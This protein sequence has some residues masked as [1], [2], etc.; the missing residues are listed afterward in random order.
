M[1]EKLNSSISDE[2]F[3]HIFPK[4]E[5]RISNRHWTPIHI[6]KMASEFLCH[7]DNLNILDIGSGVGKFCLVAA[8]LHPKCN[9]W[10]V[11]FR[12]NFVNIASKIKRSYAM[13]NLNFMCRDILGMSIMEYDGA[14]FFNA[15]QER[16]DATAKID[17]QSIRSHFQYYKYMEHLFNQFNHM[18]IGSR[19]ATYHTPSFFIPK[20]FRLEE[21]HLN[22][23]LRFYVK[24]EN[25][26]P[27]HF[28]NKTKVDSHIIINGTGSAKR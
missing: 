11:D 16:I 15:F 12:A 25:F 7:K 17:E 4:R 5:Q 6:S 23:M 14:Y 18:A 21:E 28:L 24:F 20:N 13:N 19:I 2:E 10:G 27:L 1:I 9:F 26:N 8:T 22:G 3:D